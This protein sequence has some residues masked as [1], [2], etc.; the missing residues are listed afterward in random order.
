MAG[1]ELL[2]LLPSPPKHISSNINLQRILSH[3]CCHSS[4]MVLWIGCG[5]CSPG[6]HCHWA[7]AHKSLVLL[8]GRSTGSLRSLGAYLWNTL[9]CMLEEMGL[10]GSS[11]LLSTMV[12]AVEN[13]ADA[14]SLT[15]K[16]GQSALNKTHWWLGL[17]RSMAEWWPLPSPLFHVS[18]QK[19]VC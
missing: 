16:W 15:R 7:L 4:K 19:Q 17:T 6:V 1:F 14:V 10:L 12:W 5:L 2:S 13:W 3:P 8:G 11:R 18:L 9:W